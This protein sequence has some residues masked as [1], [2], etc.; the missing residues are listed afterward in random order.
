MPDARSTLRHPAS[1]WNTYVFHFSDGDNLPYDNEVCKALVR[2]LLG[3]CVMVGYG[4][5]QYEGEN[6]YNW[7]G[8]MDVAMS[9]LQHSLQ[10]ISHPRLISVTITHKEQLY[11]VLRAF[12]QPPENDKI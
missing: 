5:I 1:S 6:F 12:L 3:H 8:Q 9:T 7:R 10:E 11:E 2:G 4:Q